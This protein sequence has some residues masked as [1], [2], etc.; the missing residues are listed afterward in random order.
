M[1]GVRTVY[2]RGAVLCN[3]SNN[4]PNNLRELPF[5]LG[6][7]FTGYM[8]YFAMISVGVCAYICLYSI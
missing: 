6:K 3:V 8:L 7:M 1:S 5:L 2:K 4:I